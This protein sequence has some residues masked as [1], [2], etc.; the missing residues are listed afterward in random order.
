MCGRF[1]FLTP[2]KRRWLDACSYDFIAWNLL[3]KS[4]DTPPCPFC[5]G[6][7]E[8]LCPCREKTPVFQPW[9][10]RCSVMNN[11]Y[12]A[13]TVLDLTTDTGSLPPPPARLKVLIVSCYHIC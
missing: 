10:T 8:T 13:F 7:K 4:L 9:D 11:T 2:G 6:R 12:K 1:L 5:G 3:V